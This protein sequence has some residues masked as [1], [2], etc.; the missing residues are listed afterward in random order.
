MRD[1]D[2]WDDRERRFTEKP[3]RTTMSATFRIWLV[4]VLVV[5][6]GGLL[7]AGIWYFKVGTSDIRGAGNAEIIKNEAGNRIRA[8]EGFEKYFQAILAADQTINL[9]AESLKTDPGNPK[10]MTELMGQKQAC[11]I[12]VG[13]YNAKARSFSQADFRAADLPFE[14]D[15]TNPQTDCKENFK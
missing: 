3:V 5:V 6:L 11:M 15:N 8:Q 12:T 2:E 9:T 10:L 13:Q 1:Y 14:I 4:V 7:S